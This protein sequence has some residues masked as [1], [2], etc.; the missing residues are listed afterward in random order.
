MGG[1]LWVENNAGPGASFFIEL[2]VK[3]DVTCDIIPT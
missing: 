2:P 3:S 1:R